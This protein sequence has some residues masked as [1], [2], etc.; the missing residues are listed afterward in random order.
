MMRKETVR[1]RVTPELKHDVEHV[2][3]TVGLSMSEAINL[4][5]AQVRLHQGLPFE[6]KIPNATTKKTL[7][8]ADK[9]LGLHTA[10]DVDDLFK[11]LNG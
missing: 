6:V 7:E 3:H 8:D 10:K 11:Q 9:G 2:L 5:M 4:F 1:A